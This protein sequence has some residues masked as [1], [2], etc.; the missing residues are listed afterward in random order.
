MEVAWFARFASSPVVRRRLLHL[1]AA[2][3]FLVQ[4]ASSSAA[5][6]FGQ[7]FPQGHDAVDYLYGPAGTWREQTN[8]YYGWNFYKH[9]ETPSHPY[10]PQAL[11]R[12]LSVNN[13]SAPDANCVLLD[14]L[15]DDG[16]IDDESV[17]GWAF[18]EHA[19]RGVLG[20]QTASPFY[21]FWFDDNWVARYVSQ[22][23]ERPSPA[24]LHDASRPIRWRVVGGDNS[25]WTPYSE[26]SPHIDQI[27]LNG[28]FKLNA[29][30]FEGALGAWN[31]IK[32]SSA[33]AYDTTRARYDYSF[34]VDAIYYYALWAMLSERL[35]AEGSAFDQ[36][37]EVLQHAM[38]L[39][40]TLLAL[41]EKD[42]SGKRLGWR[43]GIA[44]PAL[45]NTETTSLAV[46]ALG[47]RGEW[48]LEPGYAPLSSDSGNYTLADER[49][50]A[51][52]GQS[53]P[54]HVV[55]GPFWT[56]VPGS[57]EVEFALRSRAARVDS[58]LA[59]LDVY[60]GSAAVAVKVVD[61][62]DAPVGNQWQRYR[63]V[64]EIHDAANLT[65]FRVFWHG[66]YDLDVGAIRVSKQTAV[67]LPTASVPAVPR[68]PPE[69]QL[70][71]QACPA[72]T[73]DGLLRRWLQ[74]HN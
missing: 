60:D 63:L 54:G 3:A 8:V 13:G 40:E 74:L 62:A 59:T 35:L 1:C 7:H 39:H 21:L 65:Q 51:V 16:E 33:A 66:A 47:T 5:P 32:N 56:L 31:A 25:H 28:L 70:A 61:G 50:S 12:E 49:L 42:A 18:H 45:I 10:D 15:N 4:A 57:Y 19:G 41:Q 48:V 2:L 67:A 9:C 29:G 34:A 69:P 38:S 11:L 55:L 24:G 58:P 52:A 36:R 26:S 72:P 46:L 20:E 22:T 64:A 23:Y 30:D 43:T 37:A 68:E 14:D 27:A 53:V 71:P 73:S 17:A 44:E 6:L